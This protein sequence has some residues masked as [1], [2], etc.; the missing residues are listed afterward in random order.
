MPSRNVKFL[1]A[2]C[3]LALTSAGS[4]FAAKVPMLGNLPASAHQLCGKDIAVQI[5]ELDSDQILIGLVNKTTQNLD[6]FVSENPADVEKSYSKFLPVKFD[7]LSKSFIPTGDNQI[8]IVWGASL[9]GDQ[10]VKY[11]LALG[12]YVYQCGALKIWPNDK[13]NDLY[14]EPA[15]AD[16]ADEQT[17][18]TPDAPVPRKKGADSA[19]TKTSS[20][21]AASGKGKTQE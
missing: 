4:A 20:T 1:T 11:H 7:S 10:K 21:P 6:L 3:L 8:D 12:N 2:F 5:A 17:N 19:A 9:D 16:A 14:G 18:Q 15:E 13:A